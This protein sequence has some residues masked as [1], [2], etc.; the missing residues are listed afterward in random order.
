MRFDSPFTLVVCLAI[1]GA[2]WSRR[3]SSAGPRR[4]L[5]GIVIVFYLASTPIGAD[6]LIAS[7]SHGLTPIATREDARG[8]DTVVILSG[9]VD[10]VR[11]SGMVLTNMSGSTTLR[12]LEGARVFK[13][14]GARLVIV[15]GGIADPHAQLRPEARH[16]ADALEAVGVPADKI[17]LD[18]NATNTFDHPRT[19]RP[20]LEANGVR[21]F[22]LVTS[23]PHMRRALA[24]FHAAGLDPVPSVSLL[25]SDHLDPPLFFLPNDDSLLLSNASLYEY[26]GWAYYFLRG[27][28]R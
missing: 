16:M 1:V 2:W 13:L 14:I 22:V 17:A 26:G 21:K 28:I 6:A 20:I 10:T 9:G 19:I 15:S 11:D 12:V 27:R 24:V 3:P 25:R 23:P 4:L 18:L 5:W 7:L 8:A